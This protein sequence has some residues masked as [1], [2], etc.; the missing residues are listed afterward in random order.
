MRRAAELEDSTDTHVAM[1]NRLLPMR[2]LLGYLLLD[3]HQPAEAGRQFR[4]SLQ[5]SPNRLRSYFGAGRAAEMTGDRAAARSWYQQLLHLTRDASP[6][7]PDLSHARQFVS[8][9]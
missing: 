3:L 1:E 2:E 4:A 5:H 7:R 8:R 9:R 6:G